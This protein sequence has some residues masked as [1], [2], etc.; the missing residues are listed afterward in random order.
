MPYTHTT[1]LQVYTHTNILL[2]D[3]LTF[4]N[5]NTFFKKTHVSNVLQVN[6]RTY[7]LISYKNIYTLTYA[8]ALQVD[9]HFYRNAL[10]VNIHECLIEMHIYTNTLQADMHTDKCHTQEYYTSRYTS[11][12]IETD[13]QI[14]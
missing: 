4:I 12:Q 10:K 8:N 5:T 14:P 1:A 13:T 2:V 3:T 7:R 6:G 9:T 11:L